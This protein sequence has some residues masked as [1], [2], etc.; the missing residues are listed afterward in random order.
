MPRPPKSQAKPGRPPFKPTDAMRAMVRQ[1]VAFGMTQ[2]CICSMVGALAQIEP[3]SP[4]TLRKHFAAELKH[5]LQEAIIKVASALFTNAMTGNVAAQ[6]FFLKTRAKWR[7]TNHLE[8][9]DTNGNPLPIA[10]V[11]LD[12]AMLDAAYARALEKYGVKP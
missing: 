7:E 10:A 9:S 4:E 11:P 3:I 1:L 12:A 5:G 6:I 8:V 2:E